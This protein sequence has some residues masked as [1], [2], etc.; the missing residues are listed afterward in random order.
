MFLQGH[1]TQTN[2]LKRKERPAP[3]PPGIHD[4]DLEEQ[5]EPSPK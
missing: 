2:I 1:T 3:S 4:S 5:R